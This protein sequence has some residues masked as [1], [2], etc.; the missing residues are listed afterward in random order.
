MFTKTTAPTATPIMIRFRLLSSLMFELKKMMLSSVVVCSLFIDSVLLLLLL[1]S[2]EFVGD[3]LLAVVVIC[4]RVAVNIDDSDGNVGNRKGIVVVVV[5]VRA[6]GIGV[7]SIDTSACK[8]N[9]KNYKK[10]KKTIH[11]TI[12]NNCLQPNHIHMD[13]QIVNKQMRQR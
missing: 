13:H 2:D 1:M 11:L 8:K 9:N 4:T 7:G 3:W 6:I 5:I 12:P 10:K